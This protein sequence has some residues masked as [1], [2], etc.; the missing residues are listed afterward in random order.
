MH[1]A[2]HGSTNI[3]YM[4]QNAQKKTII[5]DM[6]L[7]RLPICIKILTDTTYTIW[8]YKYVQHLKYKWWIYKLYHEN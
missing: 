6:V 4:Y 3:P 2:W 5:Q 1:Y 7:Q 8:N